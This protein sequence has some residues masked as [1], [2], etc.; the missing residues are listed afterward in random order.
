MS[1]VQAPI[2]SLYIFF[3]YLCDDPPMDW[4][5]G[6]RGACL[7]NGGLNAW[8]RIEGVRVVEGDASM[9]I[10]PSITHSP[11]HHLSSTYRVSPRLAV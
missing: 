8:G 6:L 2:L 1:W 4:L 7:P 9:A 10:H 5:H 3:T 11:P